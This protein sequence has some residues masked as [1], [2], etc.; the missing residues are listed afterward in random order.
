MR[1]FII[2]A[3][4]AMVGSYF[5]PWLEPPFAGPELSPSSLIGDNLQQ[6][7]TEGPWQNWV[8]LGGFAAAGLAVIT[9]LVGRGSALFTFLAGLS[10]V[11]LIVYFRTRAEELTSDIGLPFAVD[12]QDVGQA[13]ELVGDF[14]RA[15]LYMY[16]GGAFILLLAGLAMTV[17]RN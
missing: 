1:L 5:V 6:M 14:I 13:Y 4:L 9:A 8:F 16:L 10:P 11:V 12:F 2:L 7:I 17:G 3:G 15:G